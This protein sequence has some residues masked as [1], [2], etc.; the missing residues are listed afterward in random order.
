M[1]AARSFSRVGTSRCT[2]NNSRTSTNHM[3]DIYLV[4]TYGRLVVDTMAGGMED[5]CVIV[6]INGVH[7]NK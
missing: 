4:W 2:R 1:H 5:T 7:V 6:H 3:E